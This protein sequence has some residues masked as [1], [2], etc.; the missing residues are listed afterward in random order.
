MGAD[1]VGT[2]TIRP[3]TVTNSGDG[4]ITWSINSDAPWLLVAPSQGIFSQQAVISVAVQR[5]GLQPGT[6]HGALTITST[7]S[8]PRHIS[9]TMRVQTIR[10]TSGPVLAVTPALLPF[11]ASDGQPN[12]MQQ[13]LT[14][15]NPG[16]QPLN[17]SQT[18]A[19]GL[20]CPWLNVSPAGGIVSP[21]ATESLTVDVGSNC[22]LPG[23]YTS[24]LTFIA[25]GAID[26]AQQVYVSLVV[27][28]HC[29][30]VTSTGFLAFTVV[31]GN[32]TPAFQSL[33]LNATS[34]CA[35]TPLSWA[36]SS[37]ESWL[38][39]AP[40]N[41]Q[42]QV[43]ASSVV[44]A[45]V[46]AAGLQASPNPYYAQMSFVFGQ[47]TLTVVVKLTV[48]MAQPMAPIMSVSPLSLNF[49]NIE[50][51]P[52][53]TGQVVA[54]TNSGRSTL[55]WQ[56]TATPS[57][58]SVWFAAQPPGGTIPP[59]QTGQ[60]TV[61]VNTAQLTPGNYVGQLV[62]DGMDADGKVALGNPQILMVNLVIQPPCTISPPS[63][64]ALSLS[65]VQG[66]SPPI[67]AQSVLFTGMGSCV[68][69]LLWKAS[70]APTARWLTLNT[71][72]GTIGGAGQSGNIGL[73]ANITGLVAGT[74]RTTVT[75]TAS[76][77]S[78][79]TVG[80]GIQTFTVTLT[81]LPPCVLSV[82]SPNRLTFTV[83]Q[84]QSSS[85][86]L[87]VTLGESG[88]CARPVTWTA[89]SNA[90]SS[91]WIALSNSS[92]VDS[93]AGSTFKVTVHAAGLSPG[94][95]IGTI[96]ITATDSSGS[97]IAA[98]G[99]KINVSLQVI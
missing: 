39:M 44:T 28:S 40:G 97:K 55:N 57:P 60:V 32:T 31:A 76:D 80:G 11:T 20:T 30:L 6:Y 25:K 91:A 66:A 29:G 47:D 46:N 21:G 85:A 68:W 87:T 70:V 33:S 7:V 86:W 83:Q 49:S 13:T 23:T 48:E 5:L 51:Q 53:P 58:S 15:S 38:S 92:G 93:G 9:V 74:Y 17:W 82:P 89:S 69:P 12:T 75:I 52:D 71:S 1:Y 2:N 77:S 3:L 62:L 65:A 36:A 45:S 64:S 81:L 41:G 22:L 27:Q 95:Y 61:Q 14:V 18:P 96:V 34:S 37:T 84:G 94:I 59:G 43:N 42:V 24:A 56:V 88:T 54:I 90:H 78:N 73:T 67:G 98:S 4:E 50:G 10:F 79:V 72:S 8:P 99:R 19:Q 26:S 63:S 16:S 35:G